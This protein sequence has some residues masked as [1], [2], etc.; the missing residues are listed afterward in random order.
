[1]FVAK[2]DYTAKSSEKMQH[3][4]HSK[5]HQCRVIEVIYH[6][7]CHNAGIRDVPQFYS[8]GKHTKSI[9]GIS[10]YRDHL[11]HTVSVSSHIRSADQIISHQLACRIQSSQEAPS[12][13]R[14]LAVISSSPCLASDLTRQLSC[15]CLSSSCSHPHRHSGL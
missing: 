3:Q 13:S 7:L 11:F 14:R 9:L 10:S 6:V 12:F 4:D 8:L 2:A 1:M 5:V 15:C